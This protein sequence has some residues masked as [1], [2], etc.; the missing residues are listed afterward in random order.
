MSKSSPKFDSLLKAEDEYLTSKLKTARAAFPMH[1]YEKGASLENVARDFIRTFLPAE[2][3]LGT[4]F[5]VW[6][7]E[8]KN[9]TRKSNGLGDIPKVVSPQLDIIIYDALRCSPIADL[10]T[11]QIFPIEAVYGYVEVKTTFK[12][13][14]EGILSV[15]KQLRGVN[16]R[17][18]WTCRAKIRPKQS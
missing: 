16:K 7:E 12:E 6:R 9:G 13:Y 8:P 1:E 10:G 2:Y 17:Y 3:G 5:I 14:I 11:A 15:A 18:Y 4:G